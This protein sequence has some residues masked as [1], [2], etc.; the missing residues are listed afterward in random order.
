MRER[1]R[2]RGEERREKRSETVSTVAE[3]DYYYYCGVTRGYIR[4]KS[5]WNMYGT[6]YNTI[7][8]RR[9]K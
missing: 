7:H 1:G 6:M 3:R 8:C 5:D 2:G 9:A 4:F